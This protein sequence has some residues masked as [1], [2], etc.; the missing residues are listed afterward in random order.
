MEE[1]FH[2]AFSSMFPHPRQPSVDNLSFPDETFKKIEH[3]TL[4]VHGREDAV[5][6]ITNSE[7][8]IHLLPNAELHIFGGCGH[9]TQIEKSEE[10]AT[11][12]KNFIKK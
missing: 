7:R 1:G 6:P 8:L 10:F 12:V 3:Q 5:V 11:L 9:W 2:E 4:L